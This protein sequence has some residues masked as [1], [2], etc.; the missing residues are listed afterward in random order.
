MENRSQ[1]KRA[2]FQGK[3]AQREEAKVAKAEALVALANAKIEVLKKAPA[4]ENRRL[5]FH[6]LQQLLA[7]CGL[8]PR[9]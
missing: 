8:G 4:E 9:L 5:S 7:E 1:L 3:R 6:R 2:E